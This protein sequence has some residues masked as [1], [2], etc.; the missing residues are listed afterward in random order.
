MHSDARVAQIA[1][2]Q[3]GVFSLAQA[4]RAGLSVYNV[5]YRVRTGRYARRYRRCLPDRWCAVVI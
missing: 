2:R 5:R 1:E 4:S 3:F